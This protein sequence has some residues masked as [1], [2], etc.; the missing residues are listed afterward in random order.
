MLGAVMHGHK[1][2]QPVIDMIISLAESCAKEPWD[3]PGGTGRRRAD[4]GARAGAG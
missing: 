3:L 4:E 2:F 1:E